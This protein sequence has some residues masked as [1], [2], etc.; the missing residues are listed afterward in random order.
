MSF[1]YTAGDIDFMR[2]SGARARRDT[3]ETM[4]D[5]R[6]VPEMEVCIFY[7]IP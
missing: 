7:E 1:L 2:F 4:L 5:S 3:D 6:R